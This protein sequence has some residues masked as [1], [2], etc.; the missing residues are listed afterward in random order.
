[1]PKPGRF[2]VLPGFLAGILLATVAVSAVAAGAVAVNDMQSNKVR[3]DAYL[4]AVS[5]ST[6]GDPDTRGILDTLD[7]FNAGLPAGMVSATTQ[8]GYDQLNGAIYGT[9]GTVLLQ[10]IAIRND[11][12][13]AMLRRTGKGTPARRTARDLD[14]SVSLLPVDAGDKIFLKESRVSTW[15]LGYGIGG[16]ASFDGDV[17]GYGQATGGTLFGFG[18]RTS[19]KDTER[20]DLDSNGTFGSYTESRIESNGLDEYAKTMELM[21][22][23]YSHDESG[24]QYSQTIAA[25]GY[26]KNRI[27]R[28]LDLFD[29]RAESDREAFLGCWYSESGSTRHGVLGSLQTFYGWQYTGVHQYRFTEQGAGAA[30]LIGKYGT[31]H[32]FRSMLGMRW[33]GYPISFLGGDLSLNGNAIWWCEWVDRT[34]TVFTG[35]LAGA[36]DSPLSSRTFRAD[37][38]DPGRNWGVFG[39]GLTYDVGRCRIFAGYDAFVNVRQVLHTGNAGLNFSW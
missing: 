36:S 13:A 38:N 34:F 37:G 18:R 31:T 1:M 12:L 2:F 7:G 22:G 23:L 20:S 5:L 17:Q 39:A 27:V 33:N 29:R 9:L 4:D 28:A 10:N 26:A 14:G 25:L 19:T 35:K 21:F 8:D 16:Q 15:A 3:M 6:V 30:N 24:G 11:T 32:S